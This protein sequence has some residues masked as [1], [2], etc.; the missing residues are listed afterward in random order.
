MSVSPSAGVAVF[1]AVSGAVAALAASACVW[2]SERPAEPDY[3]EAPK[4]PPIPTP[5]PP[6]PPPPPPSALVTLPTDPEEEAPELPLPSIVV[7]EAVG[8]SADEASAMF[9]Q[10]AESL[11][12]CSSPGSGVV[13]VRLRSKRDR[14]R[15]QIDP[16]SDL[17]PERREC[18]LKALSIVEVE[19]GLTS[20]SS[21][22]RPNELR[23]LFTISW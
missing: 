5:E 10:A 4:A 7:D 23:S 9:E 16:S 12:E 19:N 1:V 11:A 22:G 17:D 21:E 20:A 13:R 6:A 2:T 15:F 3:G 14:T 8:M 18:V